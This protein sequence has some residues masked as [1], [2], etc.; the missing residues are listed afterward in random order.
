MTFRFY[1]PDFAP[2]SNSPGASLPP[3]NYAGTPLCRCG[4]PTHLRPDAR[5]RAK[6]RLAGSSK[7]PTGAEEEEEL[8][9]FW[10]CNAGAQ[11][12]GKTCGYF[13]LLNME[14]EGR[15]KAWRGPR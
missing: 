4:T 2:L 10:T 11:D 9:F 13:E 3:P 8:L 15:G 1:R 6:N 7:A 14:K 5:G 12:K